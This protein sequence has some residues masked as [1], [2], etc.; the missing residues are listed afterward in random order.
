MNFLYLKLDS[1]E[2][3]SKG[4]HNGVSAGIVNREI[5]E[6]R[7]LPRPGPLCMLSVCMNQIVIAWYLIYGFPAQALP[8]PSDWLARV[9]VHTFFEVKVLGL[10]RLAAVFS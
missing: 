9:H 1:C 2:N 8:L 6:G 4:I 3:P 7:G 10:I 5:M